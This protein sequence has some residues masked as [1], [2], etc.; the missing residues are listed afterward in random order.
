MWSI[1]KGR[2]FQMSKINYSTDA[3]SE[4]NERTSNISV[5]K[6]DDIAFSKIFELY[7][8]ESKKFSV[9]EIGSVP[10]TFLVY[11]H[12]KFGYR[13]NGIDF[14][15]NTEVF[16][17]TMK[18]NDIKDYSFI[19]ADFFKYKFTRQYDVV[20]S[21]GFIEHFDDLDEVLARHEA[22]VRPGGYLVMTL[23][24][25]RFLQHVYHYKFDRP[26]LEIHNL[27]AMNIGRL[28]HK[29]RSLGLKKLHAGYFGNLQVWRE[30][31]P[32]EINQRRKVNSIHTWVG[33][34]GFKM[35]T[36]RLYSPYIVLIYRKPL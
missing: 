4:W 23:P 16:H 24:N 15:E 34:H 28:K 7:L 32:L 13:V 12:K 19:N 8:P 14:A 33:K 36:F 27:K 35:P 22:L 29:L 9:L 3:R 1:M 5:D 18:K 25:F 31:T 6:V 26:N 17:E 21:F 10:G 2:L 30:D 11:F 20:S